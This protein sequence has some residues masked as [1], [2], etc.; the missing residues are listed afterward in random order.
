MGDERRVNWGNVVING[1]EAAAYGVA[2]TAIGAGTG[3]VVELLVGKDADPH[4]FPV[5]G[6]FGLAYGLVV[7]LDTGTWRPIMETEDSS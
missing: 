1:L 5:A 7:Y 3:K 2:G 6:F 4:F